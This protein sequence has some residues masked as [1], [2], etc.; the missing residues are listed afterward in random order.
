MQL[1][2]TINGQ[3]LFYPGA[4]LVVSVSMG[5]TSSAPAVIAQRS[6]ADVA[7][8]MMTNPTDTAAIQPF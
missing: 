3:L 4:K 1:L 5:K 2:A 7:A 6:F 8:H